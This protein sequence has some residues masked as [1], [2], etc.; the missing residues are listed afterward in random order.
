MKLSLALFF[1]F[2]AESIALIP[3]LSKDSIPLEVL[4]LK[5]PDLSFA[6]FV[7]ARLWLEVLASEPF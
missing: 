7:D 1:L 4:S 3:S 6:S 5:L 2:V